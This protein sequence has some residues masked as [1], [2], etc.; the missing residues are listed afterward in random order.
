MLSKYESVIR[1]R[2]NGEFLYMTENAKLSSWLGIPEEEVKPVLDQLIARNVLR[3]LGRS[4][5]GSHKFQLLPVS[6][7]S[8][9]VPPSLE[10]YTPKPPRTG[11]IDPF[12]DGI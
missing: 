8:E 6:E 3:Y 11:S 2:V 1:E 7:R 4:K 12:P 5:T 9:T 10:S